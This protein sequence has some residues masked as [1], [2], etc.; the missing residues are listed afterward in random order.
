MG[1]LLGCQGECRTGECRADGAQKSPVGLSFAL[2]ARVDFSILLE[3]SSRS[4][5]DFWLY[6]DVLRH[7]DLVVRHVV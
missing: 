2:R 5:I 3:R 6:E 7:S 1:S 4:E